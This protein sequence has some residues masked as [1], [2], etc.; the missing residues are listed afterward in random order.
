MF[1]CRS[2]PLTRALSHQDRVSTSS[3][4]VV[5]SAGDCFLNWTEVLKGSVM[6]NRMNLLCTGVVSLPALFQFLEPH[7]FR[8][9]SAQAG[10]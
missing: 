5:A 6:S 1:I 4:V 7:P 10:Y 3:R 8:D 2:R 9:L